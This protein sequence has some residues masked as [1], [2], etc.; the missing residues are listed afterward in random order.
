V[1]YEVESMNTL[2]QTASEN[3]K[4]ILTLRNELCKKEVAK[5]RSEAPYYYILPVVQSDQG[6]LV[7]LVS[8]MQE[9]G[10]DVFRLTKDISIEQKTYKAGDIV[11][12]LAQPFRPFIKEVMEKQK[13]PER[14][15]TEGGYTDGTLRH[16]DLVDAVTH[17]TDLCGS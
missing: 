13:Y 17:G 14:H 1:K 4:K 10:I 12:P 2:L 11:I 15:F 3:K 8:L 7:H 9:H 6:E 16:H 5:G